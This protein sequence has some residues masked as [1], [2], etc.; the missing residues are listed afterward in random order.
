MTGYDLFVGTHCM[1]RNDLDPD[2]GVEPQDRVRYGMTYLY[3]AVI[4]YLHPDWFD[5]GQR[6]TASFNEVVALFNDYRRQV[7][8]DDQYEEYAAALGMRTAVTASLKPD[9]PLNICNFGLSV[10]PKLKDKRFVHKTLRSYYKKAFPD[11][12]RA[13][14]V[15][16]AEAKKNLN[17]PSVLERPMALGDISGNGLLYAM[18]SERKLDAISKGIGPYVQNKTLDGLNAILDCLD[19]MAII[20]LGVDP[21]YDYK[22]K[23]VAWGWSLQDGKKLPHLLCMMRQSPL[24]QTLYPTLEACY[25]CAEEFAPILMELYTYH[26]TNIDTSV[27]TGNIFF[28]DEDYF[29]KLWG[30]VVD[31]GRMI[32]GTVNNIKDTVAKLTQSNSDS[33]AR[34][35]ALERELAKSKAKAESAAQSCAK[36]EQEDNAAVESVKNDLQRVQEE[37]ERLK[38][39]LERMTLENVKLS[40]CISEVNTRYAALN[41]QL[42]DFLEE[43][44]LFLEEDGDGQDGEEAATMSG[45]RSR[46][47]EEAYQKLRNMRVMIVGGHDN[48]CSVL[49]DLFPE[50]RYYCGDAPSVRD[51]AWA[52]DA[53]ACITTYISH[54]NFTAAR[55]KARSKG[56]PFILVPHNSPT[57]ICK[58]LD[59]HILPKELETASA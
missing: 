42:I 59:T 15:V 40:G 17:R 18:S 19:A 54:S 58:H 5:G 46:I 39:E 37:N 6:H 44:G 45:V 4:E 26:Q 57:A 55:E 50:W 56:I 2:M 32:L 35:A 53:I 3:G 27:M 1:A 30:N 7:Q 52:V 51:A 28:V 8:R 43:D 20:L 14:A 22:G 41:E 34:I 9:M 24:L 23:K 49:R 33:E 31:R 38:E 10:S 11:S 48:T 12:K 13:M 36:A 47:G 21:E 25:I 29:Q 16:D